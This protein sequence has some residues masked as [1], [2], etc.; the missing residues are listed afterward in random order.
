MCSGSVF[1]YY[2]RV[3]VRVASPPTISLESSSWPGVKISL[4]ELRL[5]SS[6]M[7]N[8]WIFTTSLMMVDRSRVVS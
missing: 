5:E 1:P 8:F 7:M 6:L 3:L 2:R 4:G